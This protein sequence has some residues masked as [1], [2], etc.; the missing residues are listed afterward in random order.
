MES[1]TKHRRSWIPLE[2]CT[3]AAMKDAII[4]QALGDPGTETTSTMIDFIDRRDLDDPGTVTTSTNINC[5][6]RQFLGDPGTRTTS[7]MI[8]RSHCQDLKRSDCQNRARITDIITH[9]DLGDPIMKT[10][11]GTDADIHQ[12]IPPLHHR[13][14]TSDLLGKATLDMDMD[15]LHSQI[16]M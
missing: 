5:I 2:P 4:Y 10:T 6:V 3:L 7:E 11:A 14:P 15:M 8:M 16:V 12:G 9:R 13:L 1:T